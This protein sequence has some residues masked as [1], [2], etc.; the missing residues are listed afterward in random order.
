MNVMKR[1][2]TIPI[3][4][5]FICCWS[6]SEDFLERYPLDEL[7]PQQYFKT[8]NDLKLYANSFYTLLPAHQMYFGGTFYTDQNSDN[9]LPAVADMRLSGIRTVP[10]SGGGWNWGNI[11]EA[12]YFLDHTKDFTDETSE[13]SVYIAEVKFFKAALYFEMVKTF[14]DVPWFTRALSTDSPELF[15]PRDSR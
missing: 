13:G 9:L 12:N 3:L 15:A 8:A 5:G 4:L 11:R 2:I 14:G 10:S 7:S 1:Y 6:C